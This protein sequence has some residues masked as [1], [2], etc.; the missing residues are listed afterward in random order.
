MPR[1]CRRPVGGLAA[2]SSFTSMNEM[3]RRT[4]PL[5]PTSLILRS[6]FDSLTKIRSV[7]V[8]TLFIHGS[9]DSTVPPDMTRRLA[10]AAPVPPTVIMVP[11]A[12]H[13]DLYGI[14]YD[15]IRDGLSDLLTQ[16]RAR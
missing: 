12:N 15:A 6:R 14:G 11:D 9:V 5:F 10:A 7:R 3:A 13:N 1:S 2:I 8:P 16:V 4:A